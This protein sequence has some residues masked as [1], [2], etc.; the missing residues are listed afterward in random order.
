MT[1]NTYS[2]S[3]DLTIQLQ[4]RGIPSVQG[5]EINTTIQPPSYTVYFDSISGSYKAVNGL[6]GAVDFNGTDAGIVIQGVINTL[7][8]GGLIFFKRGIY[9]INTTLTIP[10]G[11]TNLFSFQG[12]QKRNTVLYNSNGTLSNML[13]VGDN[14]NQTW[15]F[16]AKDIM[17]AGSANNTTDLV[18][19]RNIIFPIFDNCEFAV[20][21]TGIKIDPYGGN[22]NSAYFGQIRSCDFTGS[23]TATPTGIGILF[24]YNTASWTSN[25][26]Q[27]I[28]GR[29]RLCSVGADL[30]YGGTNL[31]EGVDFE[32]N[33]IGLRLGAGSDENKIIGSRF[34]NNVTWDLQ[35]ISGAFDNQLVANSFNGKVSNSGIR[36]RGW[37]NIGFVTNNSGASTGTGVQQAIPHGLAFIPTRQQIVLTAGYATGSASAP[38]HSAVPDATN[39]YVI[40]AFGKPWYWA[41]V[42]N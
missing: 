40:A 24:S 12:E 2:I 18:T 34:E 11:N 32:T 23:K 5:Q 28:G 9:P 1:D 25:A 37:N 21:K 15:G 35:I 19:L 33:N 10:G 30:P 17:F 36:T 27:I 4:T 22:D 8:K 42:G 26:N 7:T 29:I 41:T 16:T 39:I 13:I 31:F 14:L 3:T 38:Y 6:T 20:F